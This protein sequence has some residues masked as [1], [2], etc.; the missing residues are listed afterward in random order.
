MLK[1]VERVHLQSRSGFKSEEYTHFFVFIDCGLQE[2][3]ITQSWP[4]ILKFCQN[5]LCYQRNLVLQY[6]KNLL[7]S[8]ESPESFL[9]ILINPPLLLWTCCAFVVR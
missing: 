1:G 7:L 4:G 9:G 2:Q 3:K 5:L 8:K 6:C